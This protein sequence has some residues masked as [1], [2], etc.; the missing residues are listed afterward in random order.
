VPQYKKVIDGK[1]YIIE[2]DTDP[3]EAEVREYL[4]SQPQPE[5]KSLTGFGANVLKSGGNFISDLFQGGKMLGGLAL[6]GAKS[7]TGDM[8]A[9][10]E[11]IEGGRN[12]WEHKG[13]IGS[14]LKQGFSDRYGGVEQVKNTLYNDPVGAAGDLST[15]FSG[16][17]AASKVGGLSKV[18]KIANT[19]ANITDPVMALGKAVKPI[20]RE[21]ALDTVM[22]A[23][24][25]SSRLREDFGGARKIAGTILDEGL[26]SSSAAKPKLDAGKKAVDDLLALVD[27]QRPQVRGYL[28]PAREHV[29]LGPKPSPSGGQTVM[30]DAD[31][32]GPVPFGVDEQFLGTPDGP[33]IGDVLGGPGVI[34]KDNKNLGAPGRVLKGQERGVHVDDVLGNLFGEP[35]GK[36][37]RRATLGEPDLRPALRERGDALKQSYPSG[38]IPLPEANA[39]KR[40]AQELAYESGKDNLSINK[41]AQQS[42]ARAL[43]QG[44]EEKVPEVGPMNAKEAELLGASRTLS[45]AEGRHLP[46]ATLLSLLA[47]GGLG[48]TSNPLH[49]IA[50][51]ALGMGATSP[52]VGTRLGIG[53]D[54]LGKA[55][56]SPVLSKTALSLRLAGAN[57]Q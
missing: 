40:E 10:K 51:A 13:D 41:A 49:G 24:W 19:A 2:A 26:T 6:K 8:E 53:V 20:L 38:D 29:P 15:L 36:A 11:I 1:S 7:M 27:A 50:L 3:S 22:A 55:A 54:R 35:M 21:G 18:A 23:A 57:K 37:S 28:P 39:L 42:Q 14:A 31:K 47:G 5:E 48:I 32:G 12:L 30:F 16:V 46:Y 43:R 25:P 56:A 17:G 45:E 52:A 44:I 9:S 34:V 4:S 33:G